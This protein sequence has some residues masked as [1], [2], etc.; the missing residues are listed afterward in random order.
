MLR[1][2]TRRQ[3]LG[4]AA[5]AAGGTV[6]Y[7]FWVEPFWVEVVRRD[8]PVAGL[9]AALEGK[10]LVQLSDLH[11]GKRVPDS[12]L[13]GGFEI[14]NGLQP[15]IVVITGDFMSSRRD[16][17]VGRVLGLIS[18]LKP[19]RLGTFA[20]LGNHDYGEGF[21]DPATGDRLAA[22]LAGEG[23]TVLRNR[24]VDVAGLSIVGLDDL[25]GPNWSPGEVMGG[26]AA[27]A[28]AVVLCHNPDG[29]DRPGWGGYRGW[30]LSGHTHGGQCR[31]PFLPAPLVPV[32]NRRYVAG[33]VA[34]E[35]GR[36]VYI[37][38]ALGFLRQMRFNVRPEVTVFRLTR[39]A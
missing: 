11:A 15:D 38:R 12:L 4:L 24:R 2:L 31:P 5:L 39:A 18:S 23:V 36:R 25:W 21:R 14:V 16:E 32:Q 33:E 17:E 1:K 20:I 9:P 6:A 8:L 37:N 35:D 13:L 19:G 10:T 29:L 3:W 34:L 26:L 7:T 30:V 28:P 22:G 27:D